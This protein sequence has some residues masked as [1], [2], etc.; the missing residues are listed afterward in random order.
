MPSCADEHYSESVRAKSVVKSSSGGSLIK[1]TFRRLWNVTA[2]DPPEKIAF[3][4]GCCLPRPVE[5]GRRDARTDKYGDA[6]EQL[7]EGGRET[8]RTR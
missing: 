8:K 5:E 6:V 7:S 1:E 3:G 4:R 2:G